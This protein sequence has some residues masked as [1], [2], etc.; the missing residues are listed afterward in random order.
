MPYIFLIALTVLLVGYAF[1]G[2]SFA[3]L[4]YAPIYVGEIVFILGITIL[5]FNREWLYLRR[6]NV[7]KWLILFILWGA[8]RT[9]PYLSVYGTHCCPK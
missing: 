6:L 8:L 5:L 3:Y 1:W 2:R 9:I 4:G 7:V